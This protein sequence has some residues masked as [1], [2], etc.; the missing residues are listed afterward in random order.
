MPFFF[1]ISFR[2][3]IYGLNILHPGAWPAFLERII[4]KKNLNIQAF[5]TVGG[6]TNI[7]GERGKYERKA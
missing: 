5:S 3:L 4:K 6:S 1:F 2:L 7:L